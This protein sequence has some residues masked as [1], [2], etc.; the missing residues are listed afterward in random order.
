MPLPRLPWL[1]SGR[2]LL[3]AIGCLAWALPG[4]RALTNSPN[5]APLLEIDVRASSEKPFGGFKRKPPVDHG[6]VYGIFAISEAATAL[7]LVRPVNERAML[8][9]LH[10]ELRRRG[11]KLMAPDQI[12]DVALTV[13]YGRG[14]L[15][16]PYLADATVNEIM[17]DPPIVTILGAFP[18]QL[19][20][21]REPGY[22][23]KL[24]KAQGEKLFIRVTAWKIPLQPK[25]KAKELWKTTIIIDDPDHRDLNEYV[26]KMLAAGSAYFDK[27]ID[28]EQVEVNTS[29]PD[30]HVQV[31][32]PT[33][34]KPDANP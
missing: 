26:Q 17:S 9:E 6:K 29:V 33:V 27:E 34:V 24:Q 2:S 15:R 31:G 21:E 4:A 25:E 32:T 10:K 16:N 28:Q 1:V 7:R 13:M 12:P 30:G 23:D 5:D 14:A 22:E 8:V 18:T 20:K 11:Y 3:A 19:I